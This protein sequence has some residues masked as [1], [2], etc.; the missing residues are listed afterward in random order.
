MYIGVKR[1][2]KGNMS[3]NT[4]HKDITN[5]QKSCLTTIVYLTQMQCIRINVMHGVAHN[6]T[7]EYIKIT[8][9]AKNSL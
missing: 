8:N 9:K 2:S 6:S 3:Q 5:K 4:R 1:G 7:Q